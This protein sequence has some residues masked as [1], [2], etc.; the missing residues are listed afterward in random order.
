MNP[1]LQVEW[2]L[3]ITIPQPSDRQLFRNCSNCQSTQPLGPTWGLL[4]S[5]EQFG[6]CSFFKA[7][8]INCHT[9]WY[10]YI[11]LLGCVPLRNS[12]L[13]GQWPKS[14][15]WTEMLW[16]GNLA[17]PI[18]PVEASGK[19]FHTA[20]LLLSTTL[21]PQGKWP[22]DEI[23]YPQSAHFSILWNPKLPVAH[24]HRRTLQP[25]REGSSSVVLTKGTV[26][27]LEMRVCFLLF[28]SCL[29]PSWLNSNQWSPGRLWMCRLIDSDVVEERDKHVHYAY[30]VTCSRHKSHFS[31]PKKKCL[32][33]SPN[34]SSQVIT[35]F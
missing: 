9:N 27:L 29:H 20:N 3:V 12:W 8:L 7:H 15:R 5:Q 23:V 10:T 19:E 24:V 4:A 30:Y 21:R 13:K 26:L 16:M 34:L 25:Q 28:P 6:H 33:L 22:A 32:I 1:I 18:T 11:H 14:D 31:S 17:W 2:L 35:D